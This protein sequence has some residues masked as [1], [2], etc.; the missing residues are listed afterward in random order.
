MIMVFLISNVKKHLYYS[1]NLTCSRKTRSLPET[2][3]M[4]APGPRL[5]A[6]RS[7]YKVYLGR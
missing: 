6:Y 3:I 4:M 1:Y 2:L 5:Y 7:R